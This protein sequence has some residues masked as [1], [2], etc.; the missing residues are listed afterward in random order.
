MV[1]MVQNPRGDLDTA[2]QLLIL[3]FGLF[4]SISKPLIF[5]STRQRICYDLIWIVSFLLAFVYYKYYLDYTVQ[6]TKMSHQ[7]IVITN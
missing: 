2:D 3:H 6:P 4:L 7:K 1:F 5:T